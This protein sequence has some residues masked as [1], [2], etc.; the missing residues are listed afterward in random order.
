MIAVVIVLAAVF[1]WWQDREP[2]VPDGFSEDAAAAELVRIIDGDTIVVELSGQEERVRL[3][4]IDTPETVHPEEPVECGGPEASEAIGEM[5][6]PGD[7]LVLEFDQER[8]DQYDRLLAGV[9]ADE[10]FVNEELARQGWAE[11]AYYAPNDRFLDQI[12]DAWA[13]AESEGAGVFTLC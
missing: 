8:R 1:S 13:Q 6:S 12:E 7:E 4:N 5:I 3:L 9:F 2:S 11:P 10:V